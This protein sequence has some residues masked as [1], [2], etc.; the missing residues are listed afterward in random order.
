MRGWEGVSSSQDCVGKVPAGAI[1]VSADVR[2]V[3]VGVKKE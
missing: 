3:S 2:T 1:K